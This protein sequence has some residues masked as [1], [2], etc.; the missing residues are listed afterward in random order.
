MRQITLYHN[1]RCS[2]SREVLKLLLEQGHKPIIY[3]YLK[4]SLSVDNIVHLLLMLNLSPREAIRK[5]EPAYK[6]LDL[7][8]N[9]L[10]DNQLIDAI[11]AYPI[12]LQRPIVIINEQAI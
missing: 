6:E 3:E 11:V 4:E 7:D 10:T 1:P 8:H 5:N 2:K 12:L 9:D